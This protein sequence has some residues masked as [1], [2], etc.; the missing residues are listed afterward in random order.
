[1]NPYLGKN[2]P[3]HKDNMLHCGSIKDTIKAQ[4]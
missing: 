1:V 4:N 3:E 2:H